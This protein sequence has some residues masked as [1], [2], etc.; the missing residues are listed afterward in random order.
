MAADTGRLAPQGLRS[1]QGQPQATH[2]DPEEWPAL[3]ETSYTGQI[4][5]A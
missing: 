1:V 3:Q 4:R 5:F 2:S